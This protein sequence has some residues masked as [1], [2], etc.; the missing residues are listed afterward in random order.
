M[1][2]RRSLTN[3]QLFALTLVS[4][5]FGLGFSPRKSENSLNFGIGYAT[6]IACMIEGILL[7]VILLLYK[8]SQKRTLPSLL[9]EILGKYLSRFV[10]FLLG[11]YEIF[12]CAYLLRYQLKLI[13]LFL[14]E[15]TPAALIAL[16]YLFTVFLLTY[17]GIAQLGR[18]SEV[19]FW[20]FIAFFI[21]LLFLLS[22]SFTL[23]ELKPLW[24]TDLRSTLNQLELAQSSLYGGLGA[25]FFCGFGGN[26]EGNKGEN[27]K[28]NKKGGPAILAGG[29]L[30]FILL[31]LCLF[32]LIGVFT[33]RGSAD[34]LFPLGQLAK[35]VSLSAPSLLERS[36]LPFLLL[37]QIVILLSA[38]LRLYGAGVSFAGC[39]GSG[40]FQKALFPGALAVFIL[41]LSTQNLPLSSSPFAYLWE[42]TLGIYAL[43]P[44]LLLIGFIRKKWRHAH[45]KNS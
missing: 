13:S 35:T 24:E 22:S 15:K 44:L 25:L 1:Q 5:S 11:I 30:S 43:L 16:L 27:I 12:L 10:L 34:V 45:E 41:T 38:A 32:L 31:L 18:I 40:H 14:L 17:R 29:L 3:F 28:E 36:D 7:F 26:K 2:E 23:K 37:Y 19:F 39:L 4:L 33:L 9:T 8:S 21:V 20:P 6:I 42:A